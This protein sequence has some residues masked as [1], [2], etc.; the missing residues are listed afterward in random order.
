[1]ESEDDFPLYES[2]DSDDP[3][4]VPYLTKAKIAQDPDLKEKQFD[5]RILEV[6]GFRLES[7]KFFPYRTREGEIPKKLLKVPK[8]DYIFECSPLIAKD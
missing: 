1:M 7:M 6:S 5:I 2:Q 3:N 8:V 4:A